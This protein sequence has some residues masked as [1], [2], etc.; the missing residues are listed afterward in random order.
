MCFLTLTLV[1]KLTSCRIRPPTICKNERTIN[2]KN[3]NLIYIYI[4]QIYGPI[5]DCKYTSGCNNNN[6]NNNSFL[7][8]TVNVTNYI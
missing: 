1:V 7:H 3:S 2:K 8:L 6:E 5:N 4:K